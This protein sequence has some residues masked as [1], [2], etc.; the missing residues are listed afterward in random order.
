LT[1]ASVTFQE[2]MNKVLLPFLRKFILVFFDNILIYNSS[3]AKH[4]HHVR[5]VLS[6][7]HEHQLYVKK[8]KCAFGAR[9]VAYIGHV[10]SIDG[11]AMDRQKVQT[12][13]HRLAGVMNC[14]CCARV[15]GLGGLLASLHLGIRLHHGTPATVAAQGGVPL[16]RRCALQQALTMTH[17]FQLPDFDRDFVV[18][19]NAFGSGFGAVLHQGMSTY[20]PHR[21]R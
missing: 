14:V 6:K 7:L 13:H 20:H 11:I 17:V 1:N 4:L 15:P 19:C 16:G 10:I 12:G 3:W 8:S 5:L 21:R 9:S 2:L 18:E